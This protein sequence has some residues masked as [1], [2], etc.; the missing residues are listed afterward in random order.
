MTDSCTA[1]ILGGDFFT[2]A[3]LAATL[4]KLF[5]RFDEKSQ[6]K[7][8]CNALRA[9]VGTI[10]VVLDF[11]HSTLQ[12]VDAYYDLHY[13]GRTIQIRHCPN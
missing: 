7:V 5:L 6:D 12:T 8:V 11:G 13:T 9:E 10:S 4:T 3:V 1:L 2:G